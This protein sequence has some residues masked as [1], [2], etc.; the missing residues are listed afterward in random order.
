MLASLPA[1][2]AAPSAAPVIVTATAS[3][4]SGSKVDPGASVTYTL[5]A[6]PQQALPQGATVV[7]DLSGLL[8][9]ASVA[10]SATD[11]ANQGLT[12][13]PKTMTLTW[14]LPA[15]NALNAPSA[16]DKASFEV[17]VAADLPAGT[18]LTTAA[19]LQGGT[20]SPGDPCA[21]SLTVADPPSST[22]TTTPAGPLGPPG[23][24]AGPSPPAA[25]STNTTTR[26]PT[27][28]PRTTPRSAPTT[29]AL[30][31]SGAAATPNAAPIVNCPPGEPVAANATVVAGF[32][33]D[34]NLCVNTPG[35]QDWSNTP[36]QPV[37]NDGFLDNTGFTGGASEA[38]WPWSPSNI[39][40]VVNNGQSQQDIGN[41][42]ATSIISNNQVYV[43]LG[44]TRRASGSGTFADTVELN[45]LP[46]RFGP[47]P[48]RTTGDLRLTFGQG[49]GPIS[50]SQAVT[51]SSSGPNSGRWVPLPSTT[52]FTGATNPGAV[53]NPFPNAT[54]TGG[55]TF[56]AFT[57]GEVA[58]NLTTLFATAASNPCSAQYGTLNMRSSASLSE[59]ASMVDWV[60]PVSLGVPS[61]CSS[62]VVNKRWT[63]DG[64]TFPNGSQPPGFSATLSLTPPPLLPAGQ[65]T[66]QF[67]D[68]Y[69]TQSN[70]TPYLAGQTV[71]IGEP[72]VTVP[73]GCTNTP[74]G[75]VGGRPL[76]PGLNRFL[77]TNAV[78]CTRLTL[79]KNVMGPPAI[80]V[81]WTLS[82][83]GSSTTITGRSG[84]PGVTN[85]IVPPDTYSLT[86]SGGPPNY[87]LTNVSCPGAIVGGS[88]PTFTVVV[89]PGAN[90]AC[91][92][93]NTAILPV[94][95]TKQWVNAVPG[96]TVG[97]SI[98]DGTSAATGS[99]TAPST[100]TNATLNTLA[101]DSVGLNENFT[102]GSAANYTSSLVCDHGVTLSTNTGTTGSFTVPATLDAGTTI[103]CTFTNTRTASRLILQKTWINGAF[104]DTAGLSIGGA[105]PTISG[106]ATSVAAGAA[107]S[108]TDTLNQATSTIYAGQTV[109]LGETLAS[110]IGATYA[111]ALTCDNGI[112]PST[113][114]STS[115]SFTVPNTLAAGTTITCSFTNTRTSTAVTLQK[116][117]VNAVGNDQAN[118]SIAGTDPGTSGAATSTATG[119]PGSETDNVHVATAT[120]FSGETV[121][122]GEVLP[123]TNIGSYDS[124]ISCTPATGFTADAGGQSGTIVVPSTPVGT[125]CIVT[126]THT[127]SGMLTLQK[128]WVNGA[129]SDSANLSASGTSGSGTATA[130]VPDG[131]HGTSA[132]VVRIPI[133]PNESVSLGETLAAANL[134]SYTS[135][136]T[137]DTSGLM[138]ATGGR[139][140]T[141]VV[142]STTPANVTCTFTNSRTS[143]AVTLQKTWVNGAGGDQAGLL[144]IGTQ[145]PVLLRAATASATSTATGANGSETDATN[146]ATAPIFSG[147]T[148]TLHE[149]V[150]PDGHVNVGTY[151]SSLSCTN[152]TTATGTIGS[153]TVPAAPANVTC[154]FTNARTSATLRLQKTWF[155]GATNDTAALAISGV[156]PS[157]SAAATS[158][159]T[160]ATGS[161]TDAVHFATTSIYS[162]QTV[163][164]AEALGLTNTGLYTSA[165]TCDNGITPIT[166]GAGTS[167]TF[168]VPG[169]LSATT[170]V[171]CTFTNTRNEGM[172][173]LQKAWVDGA[174]NDTAVLGVSGT[175]PAIGGAATSTATGG[176]E[177]DTVNVATTLIYSGQT[178]HLAETLG[179]TNT[180]TYTSV[181]TCDNGITPI[182]T[183]TTSGSFVVPGALPATPITCTF[184]NARKPVT[185]VLTKRWVNPIPD[186]EVL[187]TIADNTTQT[188]A[189]GTSVAP[190]V[191]DDATLSAFAG[192]SINL[193]EQIIV[194][195]PADYTPSLSCDSGV[196]VSGAGGFK[197]PNTLPL[198]ATIT[199]TF[200][201]TRN[202]ATVKLQ[203]AWDNG[204]KG[205]TAA[206]SVSGVNPTVSATATSTATGAAGL[207]T[208]TTNI[209]TTQVFTGEGITLNETLASAI[210]ATYGSTLACDNGVIPSPN[211]GTS[212]SFTVSP[213][214]AGATI[215]CT[216][217]NARVQ[218][219]LTLQKEWVN[220]FNGDQAGL[221]IGGT[222]LAT[223]AAPTST[224]TSTSNGASG[225][226]LDITH[227]ASAPVFSGETVTLNEDL[228]PLGHTN[229]SPYDSNIAC[230]QPGLTPGVGGQG[231]TFAV[232]AAPVDVTCTITN[233]LSATGVLTLQK[234]WA[235]GALGDSATLNASS[236]LGGTQTAMAV[237]PDDGN[238]TSVNKVEEQSI[239]AG[240]SVDLSEVLAGTN[241]GT[242]TSALTCNQSGLTAAPDGLS[243]TFVVSSSPESVTCT[244]TNTRA[245]ATLTLE[246]T[247]FNGAPVDTAGLSISGTDAAT[248]GSAVATVP[249]GGNGLSSDTAT[250]PIFSG[251]T[252]GLNEVLPPANV[253]TYASTLAC[254]NG[255]TLLTNSG[256]GGSFTVP[257]PP[258]DVTCTF[259]NTRNAATVIVQ[260]AWEDGAKGDTAALSISGANPTVSK[261]VTSTATGAAGLE[262]DTAD[263]A[264]ATVFTG[265]TIT[266]NESLAS[267]KGA[268]YMSTLTCD[269]SVTLNLN[270]GTS[271]SI[272]VP[273]D[274]AG[275]TI[276]CTFT[277]A[278]M[279]ATLTLE[280]AWDNG[281]D[282]DQ[283]GLSI[284]GT[285]PA[286]G[287]TP[288]SAAT[289]TD[290]GSGIFVDT[291]NVASAPIFSGES[292]TL[293]EDLPPAGHTDTGAYDSA[294][295]C[296]EPGLT[297][298]SGGQGG[299]FAVPGAPVDVTCLITNTRSA[300]GLLTLQK[301]WAN[302]ALDDSATLS[303]SS[304]LGVTPQT[305]LAVVPDD[306]NGISVNKVV[307]PI[308]AGESVDLSEVLTATNIGT[309][310]FALTCD[311]PGLTA[312]NGLS[313]TFAV[314]SSTEAVTC[315]FTN[316][317][318]A[319]EPTVTK[320]VTSDSENPD[321][322]WTTEYDVAVT[323]PDQVRSTSF[324]LTDTLSFGANIT[325]NSASVTG[326]T[327]PE[328]GPAP[329][330]SWN[331]TTDTVVVA[332]GVI[333]AATT[334]H[335]TVTVN[336]TV[337]A[338]G[339]TCAAQ[340]GFLNHAAVELPPAGTVI[341]ALTTRAP[342]VNPLAVDQTASACAD[343]GSPTVTK[344]VVS[345]TPGAA[346]GQWVITYAVTVANGS[347]SQVS[348]S[349]T[350]PLGFPTGV[351]VTS[352]SA[353]RVTSALDGSEASAPQSVPG[354]TG[355]GSGTTLA[356]NQTLAASSKD[357]YTLV[358][359]ATVTSSVAGDALA[360]SAAGPGHGYF[361]SVTMT[362]GED[363]FGARAC[364][365]I[366]PTVPPSTSPHATLAATVPTGVLPLTGLILSHY[367]LVA[368]LLLGVGTTLV[369]A[370]RRR[371]PRGK[372]VVHKS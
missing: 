70:G 104:G 359:G 118:L 53:T 208:D 90:V 195:D 307:V 163:N 19:S 188:N 40:G 352:T 325:V 346:S 213:N 183:S 49:S 130:V 42:Y 64:Q 50:L 291:V 177:T 357:T 75:D 364:A 235:N 27:T 326:P 3:P 85:A 327:P 303:A 72:A 340:G 304:I 43:I 62:V 173:I 101:G 297:P 16:P 256:T 280:K 96:D 8:G 337:H 106:T 102:S 299:T 115:G 320:T 129:P 78:T 126:N 205:D 225:S 358:V 172:L 117:W 360:C 119:A 84:S 187:F 63:I 91:T 141:F 98:T 150:P 237:V 259:T 66:P 100:T 147:E 77:V 328:I 181:L 87:R 92:F 7:D 191:T 140:G 20:C 83:A 276:S 338:Q 248:T 229:T 107:G 138:A 267:A 339:S 158:T 286:T 37:Q 32:E 283:A 46:N 149:G 159:A 324:T 243:G 351:I 221:S 349:L 133:T 343:P 80:P 175:N 334:L 136:L 170:T 289:S 44:F 13:D 348:Y 194:G 201:N 206:L 298:G 244:F 67:G 240:E 196:T 218:A 347:T 38:T 94:V 302:G 143:A 204:A 203:K 273:A 184:T 199:C 166:P 179:A 2:L 56:P 284:T 197:V 34:G 186:D 110:S 301:T 207:E 317:A 251:G 210:G 24:L 314:S 236:I 157:I 252:V 68:I 41:V 123:D 198:G 88:A 11:L 254:N 23:P 271:G 137:C 232:P 122:V 341:Q 239:T 321:G 287:E 238:G 220:G 65:T 25:P 312:P 306:G 262:T 305:T 71:T 81:Q 30:A 212:G 275:A 333:A 257:S 168:V 253:G 162:G 246:K 310:G 274:V 272:D 15:S 144:I 309:Y 311:Q 120:I 124:A 154:S 219:T 127:T 1:G 185:L 223:G 270:T 54:N 114:S 293:D 22:T 105:N 153:F 169:T 258:V 47:V 176:T 51:W 31:A 160:G 288:T 226:F 134:G 189:V 265:Q 367:L 234:T 217:T 264:T 89:T 6:Q 224:A 216:F 58:I 241:T 318:P 361:N 209:A 331:G 152:A 14:T 73:P 93:T 316:S 146:V 350:D 242:Y 228:P 86:E 192:D 52:G 249:T 282:G 269:D 109:N 82:A 74:G 79:V 29:T 230:D 95:L 21:T 17:S 215:T 76:V 266:L 132:N 139:S 279:E 59:T 365:G 332:D 28:T 112:T 355:T 182:P 260:K 10:T 108:Q 164:L 113:T 39:T 292:V 294:I 148:I 354:W 296:D 103:T 308:T 245:Q 9:D 300:T 167:G 250:A 336:S 180:G 322:T 45:Q 281:F 156:E 233:T 35:L 165:L 161:Q 335:Y 372:Q 323:N 33:I 247:W 178:V 371:R 366:A 111:S 214:L 142:T 222:D 116:T 268:T 69:D 48:D 319:P 128:T 190:D 174:A 344:S 342:S 200:T 313:G 155:N 295:S 97:L 255:T 5:N 57:F 125:S 99:S 285:D 353:S 369:V 330:P 18:Q 315:T 61:T 55:A 131:G 4:A 356:T 211:T 277:N 345:M 278:R 261:T 363:Q 26:T 135:T 193:S 12:L 231:G 145:P 121:N 60:A 370:S 202:S 362:S 171:T 263:V 290:A 368:A 329:S 227:V 151:S 36:G